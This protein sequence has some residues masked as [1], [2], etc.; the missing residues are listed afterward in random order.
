M[1]SKALN[2]CQGM[3]WHFFV[4]KFFLT[5]QIRISACFTCT[6]KS[7]LTHV[8]S[9][10][11]GKKYVYLM[12]WLY[13]KSRIYVVKWRCFHSRYVRKWRHLMQITECLKKKRTP[14]LKL[15]EFLY[16][17]GNLFEFLYGCSKMILLCSGKDF[18]YTSTSTGSLENILYIHQYFNRKWHH[19]DV[20]LYLW[21]YLFFICTVEN[22]NGI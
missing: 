21:H 20:K 7:Y 5:H 6:Y 2:T 19:N 15:V 1:P 18:K 14:S 13:R 16:L 11:T 8:I 3:L 12:H 17:T 4:N 10:R 9:P 22:I